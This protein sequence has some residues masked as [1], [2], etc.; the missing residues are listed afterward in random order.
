MNIRIDDKRYAFPFY[1]ELSGKV[2]DIDSSII[3]REDGTIFN[4]WAAQDVKTHNNPARALCRIMSKYGI[5]EV[6]K[7]WERKANLESHQSISKDYLHLSGVSGLYA[8]FNWLD[9]PLPYVTLKSTKFTCM[10]GYYT[11]HVVL[12]DRAKGG[13]NSVPIKRLVYHSFN[14]IKKEDAKYTVT[15]ELPANNL[16]L[17]YPMKPFNNGGDTVVKGNAYNYNSFISHY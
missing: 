13:S 9:G 6:K 16:S 4:I 17:S 3:I 15:G 1:R 8:F 2:R 12:W 10:K 11:P 14:R 5:E 7:I